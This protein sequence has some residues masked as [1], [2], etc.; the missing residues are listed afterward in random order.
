MDIEQHSALFQNYA[1][2]PI[3][4]VKGEGSRLWDNEGN[5]YLDFMSGLAVCNLGHVPNKVKQRVQEQ[6]ERLL[7]VSNLF[8][9]S[10]QGRI[11]T[12]A[13]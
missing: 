13:C 3:T 9:T 4:L 5:E 2:F 11:G 10:N 12:F 6:L 8:H 1:K 7:H